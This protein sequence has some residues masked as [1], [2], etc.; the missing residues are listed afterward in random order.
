[1]HKV[2]RDIPKGKVLSYIEVARRAGNPGAARAVGQ[3]MSKNR[4]KNIPC[5][6]VISS[7]GKLGGYNGGIE[8]KRALLEAEGYNKV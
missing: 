3:I 5:H 8:K 2:V 1:M 7:N 4:D 6:R